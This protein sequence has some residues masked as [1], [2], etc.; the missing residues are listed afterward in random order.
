[1]RTEYIFNITQLNDFRFINCFCIS[2][3]YENSLLKRGSVS[4]SFIYLNS[5]H[6]PHMYLLCSLAWSK[7]LENFISTMLVNKSLRYSFCS[8]TN[9]IVSTISFWIVTQ[10]N[11]I[12]LV[13]NFSFVLN[14]EAWHVIVW[15]QDSV[16]S[17]LQLFYLKL[18][19]SESHY[20]S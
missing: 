4:E 3:P 9:V 5:F 2:R 10:I 20:T 8:L 17:F 7:S 11:K 6:P 16:E 19:L 12:A 18:I 13:L 15:Q 1:M 14:N